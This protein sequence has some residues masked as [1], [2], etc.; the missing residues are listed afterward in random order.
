MLKYS[1]KSFSFFTNSCLG[2]MY[3][4]S[5]FRSCT[6]TSS[7]SASRRRTSNRNLSTGSSLEYLIGSCISIMSNFRPFSLRFPINL[8]EKPLPAPSYPCIVEEYTTFGAFFRIF[9][10]IGTCKD[11]A[12]STTNMSP[13]LLDA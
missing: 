9:I 12:S 5:L 1:L 3:S 10:S 11:A 8:I 6:S 2:G 13:L 4:S 7:G